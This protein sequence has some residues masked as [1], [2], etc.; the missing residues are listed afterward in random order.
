MILVVV[1]QGEAGP[2]ERWPKIAQMK[3]GKQLLT[4]RDII[5]KWAE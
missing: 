1:R 5:E 3:V 2:Q 4:A